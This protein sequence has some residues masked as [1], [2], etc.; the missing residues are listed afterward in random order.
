[1]Q[2]GIDDF[3]VAISRGF[4]WILHIRSCHFKINYF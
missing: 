2:T 1:M 4:R 3:D